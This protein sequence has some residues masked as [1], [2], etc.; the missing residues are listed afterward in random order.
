MYL[1]VYNTMLSNRIILSQLYIVLLLVAF[2]SS[3]QPRVRLVPPKSF[4]DMIYPEQFKMERSTGA[5]LTFWRRNYF[6]NFSTLCI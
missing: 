2:F 3:R 6:L 4:S 5:D 1:T